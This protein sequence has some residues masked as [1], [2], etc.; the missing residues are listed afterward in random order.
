MGRGF[1][2]RR[3]RERERRPAD[4]GRGCRRAAGSRH[5]GRARRGL[6]GRGLAERAPVR[7]PSGRE[8]HHQSGA[9]TA[10]AAAQAGWNVA[11]LA[12]SKETLADLAGDI[13]EQA[14]EIRVGS[15]SRGLL[16]NQC[17]IV[18]LG[19]RTLFVLSEL[20]EI[21]WQKRLDFVP[22]ALTL[23]PARREEEGESARE[24]TSA[25]A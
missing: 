19:E 24:S 4:A 21:R 15:V 8:R 7:A 1:R 10:R 22:V 14:L 23:Y 13:G 9:A 12:R 25:R 2:H 16:P 17:D 20:G 18:V 6:V 5:Q 11:L 3:E